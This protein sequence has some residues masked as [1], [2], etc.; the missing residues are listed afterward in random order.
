MEVKLGTSAQP[1][2]WDPFPA[3]EDVV[4]FCIEETSEQ[5]SGQL[6]ASMAQ[7]T[8]IGWD[9]LDSSQADV[10]YEFQAENCRCLVG[11]SCPT[12]LRPRGLWPASLLC[13]WDTPGK[14]T[15]V[16]CHFLL[17]GIF[18][19][20]GLNPHPLHWQVDALLLSHQ[21]DPVWNLK[22]LD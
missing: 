18:W 10:G 1:N 7:V 3:K 4:S 12:L 8:Q 22:T 5:D 16:G 17:Q 15:G 11:K 21:G 20:Q 14:N 6:P 13:P 9:W 19:N 2:L